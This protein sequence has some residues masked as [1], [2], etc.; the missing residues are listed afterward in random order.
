VVLTSEVGGGVGGG[1]DI[2]VDVSG[3][4]LTSVGGGWIGVSAHDVPKRV[5]VG[6]V[7]VT[8][9][10][11]VIGMEAVLEEIG[12]V[13]VVVN[14]VQVLTG[15]VPLRLVTHAEVTIVVSCAGN[16]V[17]LSE[18]DVEIL[19]LVKVVNWVAVGVVTHC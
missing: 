18:K 5:R 14:G 9:I 8:G 15:T 16:V 4:V 3:L 10:V 11:V 19:S 12:R 13:L 1:V 6:L 7:R 2:G 17:M